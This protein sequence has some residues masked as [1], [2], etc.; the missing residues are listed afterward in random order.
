VK[1][2]FL[3]DQK[4]VGLS[5][6]A[7]IERLKA[8][9]NLDFR[10]LDFNKLTGNGIIHAKYL[11]VDGAVAHVG[12]QNFDWR[13]FEHIHE[14]GL[15]ITDPS[16]GAGA[17][18]LQ[19]GLARAG[20]DGAG[21]WPRQALNVARQPPDPQRDAC[22]WPAPNQFNPAGWAIPKPAAG[23]AGASE[24]R[25]AGAA[26]RLRAAQLWPERYAAILRR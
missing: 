7:T 13:S 19:S 9:P 23:L 3:L 15:R 1:I 2:R 24:K 5:S 6:K 11:V 16:G 18:D 20:A 25:S 14:T 4:G 21:A 12:S 17:G 22:W 8:I 10:V 26:A